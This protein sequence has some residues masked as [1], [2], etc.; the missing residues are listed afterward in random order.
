LSSF[1]IEGEVPATDV[2][3]PC[4]MVKVL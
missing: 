4:C 3:L 2:L 1:V